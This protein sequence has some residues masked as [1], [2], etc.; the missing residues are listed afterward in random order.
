MFYSSLKPFRSFRLLGCGMVT[1]C[2]LVA[3]GNQPKVDAYENIQQPPDLQITPSFDTQQ[4]KNDALLKK[5]L[6][7]QIK[8][9]ENMRGSVLL[10]TLDKD[11]ALQVLE[12]ALEYHHIEI[13]DQNHEQGYVVVQIKGEKPASA[14]ADATD[15]HYDADGV[16]SS[17]EGFLNNISGMLSSKPTEA[18]S[19]EIYQYKLSAKQKEG[20]TVISA[21]PV[22]LAYK[23]QSVTQQKQLFLTLYKS[24]REG[25]GTK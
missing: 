5:G 13:I 16:Y 2:L 18:G 11:T 3:C 6:G 10:L 17:G 23:V 25:F 9:N 4:G 19:E 22:K 8:L 15:E 12:S 20:V 1:G 7:E 21:L 24:L 14:K